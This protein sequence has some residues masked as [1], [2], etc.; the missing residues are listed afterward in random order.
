M[1]DFQLAIDD[2]G[3]DDVALKVAADLIKHSL[4]ERNAFRRHLEESI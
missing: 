4:A 1:A 2:G 3:T